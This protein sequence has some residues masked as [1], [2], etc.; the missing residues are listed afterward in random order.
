MV[1]EL[2]GV[3]WFGGERC[4]VRAEV[5]VPPAGATPLSPKNAARLV[6]ADIMGMS[7]LYCYWLELEVRLEGEV[8]LCHNVRDDG[9]A[10][11]G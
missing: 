10:G 8:L 7:G 4:A 3:V 2:S 6:A 1:Y 5:D 11:F 9:L